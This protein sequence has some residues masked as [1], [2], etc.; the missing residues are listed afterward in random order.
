MDVDRLMTRLNP[1]VT[2]LLRS[3]MHWL[4]SP[5]LLLLQVTG[6]RTGRRYWIPVGYQRAGDTITVLV[7]R[8]PRK[9]WWRNFRE[10]A[11]VVMLVRGRLLHGQ[12]VVVRPDS[13]A[14]RTTVE[15]TFQRVPSLGGQFGIQYDGRVGLTTSQ[16]T[17]VAENGVVVSIEVG[18]AAHGIGSR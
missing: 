1:I 10:P 18:G 11:P 2:W 13:P 3:P 16:W 14:F 12:A 6:R 7:S 15:R 5:A 17:V 8:A 4:L 9:L